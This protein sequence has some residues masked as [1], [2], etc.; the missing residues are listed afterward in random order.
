MCLLEKTRIDI[1]SRQEILSSVFTLEANSLR[2]QIYPE[3]QR[4]LS[5]LAAPEPSHR[6]LVENKTMKVISLSWQQ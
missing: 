4:I 1:T 2:L 6:L 5:A 3:T